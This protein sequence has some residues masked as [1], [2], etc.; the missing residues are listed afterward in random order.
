MPL[1]VSGFLLFRQW[2][3]DSTAFTLSV[4]CIS[5][6][7]DIPAHF[8]ERIGG[9]K[10]PQLIIILVAIYLE[11]IKKNKPSICM[12]S[13]FN[14]FQQFSCRLQIPNNFICADRL[15]LL[16]ELACVRY[17]VLL[18]LFKVASFASNDSGA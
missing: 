8:S 5:Y 13:H 2:R 1:N 6:G 16:S 10:D 18:T 3:A 17:G 15:H 7:F 14:A 12:A 4:H 9:W 11:N